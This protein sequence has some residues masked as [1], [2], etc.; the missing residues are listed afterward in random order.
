MGRKVIA[1]DGF[2]FSDGTKV[3][4]GAFLSVPGDVMHF[5]EGEWP[6]L[7]QFRF[8]ADV[9]EALYDKANV[10][11]GF[12]FSRMRETRATHDSDDLTGESEGT[13]IFNRHMVSTA[14]DHVVFGHGRHACPGR[15]VLS[16]SRF[17]LSTFHTALEFISIQFHDKGLTRHQILRCNGA[18]SDAR[19]HSYQL[20]REGGDGGR[21]AGGRLVFDVADAESQGEDLDSEEGTV[22]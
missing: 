12:R 22:R 8:A 14:P 3:P 13:G 15:S 5:D 9:H 19:A 20:R 10:F 2:T 16:A 1:P 18:Q 11:D 4:H 7:A 6:S 17:P 21:A